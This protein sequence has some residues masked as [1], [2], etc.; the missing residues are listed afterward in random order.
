M[1]AFL[2]VSMLVSLGATVHA[3]ERLT[4]LAAG[5]HR[6]AEWIERNAF[7]HPVETLTFFGI[8]PDQTVVELLPSGGWYASILAPYLAEQGRYIAAH[9]N[10]NRD[11]IPDFYQRLYGEFV[12]RI[13]NREVYGEVTVVPFDP[14]EV[15]SLGEP[16]TADL[17]VSFRNVHGWK[18]SEV[19]ADVL[20]AVHAVLKPGGVFGI[21]GHRLPED[22]RDGED[23]YDGYVKQSWVVGMAEAHGFRLLGASEINANPADTAD[24]PE[25]VWS[26]PPSLR[27]GEQDAERFQAIGES[28]RFTLKF[29]KR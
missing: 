29:I 12:E 22:R 16:G 23:N 20:R 19:F 8:E 2:M 7:R 14:P 1:R 27:G 24:H 3:D 11:D 13:S 17:V 15:V 26:L 25:G 6:S 4:A 10:M 28:D 21:V 18:R 5:D 9:W